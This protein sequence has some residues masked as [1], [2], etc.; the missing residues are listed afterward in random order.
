MAFINIGSAYKKGVGKRGAE[1]GWVVAK[2]NT[3]K[4]DDT[5]S[6][7]YSGYYIHMYSKGPILHYK[8]WSDVY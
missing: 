3:K 5:N 6:R 4:Q 8:A 7:A 1:V 2:T